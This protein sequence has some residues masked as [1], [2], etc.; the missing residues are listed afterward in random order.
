M[1]NAEKC[2]RRAVEWIQFMDGK[3]EK[4]WPGSLK[5]VIQKHLVGI[6]QI[7]YV[8]KDLTSH[9]RGAQGCTVGLGVLGMLGNKGAV[10]LRFQIFETTFCFICSHLA[11]HREN[12]ASRNADVGKISTKTIFCKTQRRSSFRSRLRTMIKKVPLM[13][14][15]PDSFLDSLINDAKLELVVVDRAIT[16]MTKGDHGDCMYFVQKGELEVFADEAGVGRPLCTLGSSAYFGEM[17]LLEQSRRTAT[18]RTKGAVEMFR[19]G[20]DDFN[21]A[22]KKF[23]DFDKA[24]MLSY[25][26]RKAASLKRAAGGGEEEEAEEEQREKGKQKEGEKQTPLEEHVNRPLGEEHVSRPLD[27][28]FIIWFGDLNYRVSETLNTQDVYAHIQSGERGLAALGQ[29]DQLRIEMNKGK[30]FDGFQEG[31]FTRFPPT[32]KYEPGTG[33]Y[34]KRAEQKKWRTPAWCDRVLYRC[35]PGEEEQASAVHYSDVPSLMLSDH[36]PVLATLALQV[37]IIDREERTKVS[38]DINRN[39]EKYGSGIP[40]VKVDVCTID[41]GDSLLQGKSKTVRFSISNT[42]SSLAYFRLVVPWEK[43]AQENHSAADAVGEGGGAATFAGADKETQWLSLKPNLGLLMPGERV[44]VDATALM[45]FGARSFDTSVRLELCDSATTITLR[46][47]GSLGMGRAEHPEVSALVGKLLAALQGGA[48]LSSEQ[49]LALQQFLPTD[50][51]TAGDSDNDYTIDLNELRMSDADMAQAVLVSISDPAVANKAEDLHSQNDGRVDG[52]SPSLRQLMRRVS[53]VKSGR[54]STS[55][56]DSARI[57]G[58][59][60]TSPSFS[61]QHRARSPSPHMSPHSSPYLGA[62]YDDSDTSDEL[63]AFVLGARAVDVVGDAEGSGAGTTGRIAKTGGSTNSIL[64][65]AN[66]GTRSPEKDNTES[67]SPPIAGSTPAARPRASSGGD[68]ASASRDGPGAAEVAAVNVN[69]VKGVGKATEKAATERPPTFAVPPTSGR[70]LWRRRSAPGG[71]TIKEHETM[72]LV[73]TCVD[74]YDAAYESPTNES[75]INP[76]QHNSKYPIGQ[77]ATC[78]RPAYTILTV[79]FSVPPTAG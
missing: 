71:M 67:P 28:D 5:R 8:K 62:E 76:S 9:V 40:E 44:E 46:A 31:D 51:G 20:K 66:R 45:P 19:L 41:F 52:R 56:K 77:C 74:V 17:A 64:K 27:H 55:P 53:G 1:A 7:I 34:D 73:S 78:A 13:Q 75:P 49:L 35:K 69:A 11:A 23:P 6:F 57:R 25:E 37:K 15:A 60:S 42:G 48:C 70:R 3:I 43:G 21:E 33:K 61:P 4:L 2:H 63:G 50:E 65:I 12:L 68:G 10:S 79:L 58:L 16:V 29:H 22:R 30:V 24:M 32:Y 14:A 54:S 36:R 39:F 26:V 72:P 47:M 18:V 59:W 38:E